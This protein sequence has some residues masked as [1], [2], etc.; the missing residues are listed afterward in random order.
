MPKRSVPAARGAKRGIS[1]FIVMAMLQAARAER[2]GLPRNSAYSWGL[3]RAI[4]F[5]AAKRGF[6]GGEA[7]SSSTG[8]SAPEGHSARELYTLGQE[9]AYRDTTRAGVYFTIGQETQTEKEFERQIEARFG[10]ASNF[11]TAWKEAES[12]VAGADRDSL[13]SGH[14]FYER[15]YRPRRDDL[16]AK[17]TALVTETGAAEG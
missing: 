3:N 14:G 15:V 12:I 11:A 13:E 8:A 10:G 1:R 5:A 6:K 9:Q 17:W 7:S 16:A 4:F 2:L